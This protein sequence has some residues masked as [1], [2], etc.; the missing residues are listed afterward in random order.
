MP[1]LEH[2][3]SDDES[4]EDTEKE[5]DEHDELDNDDHSDDSSN[6]SSDCEVSADIAICLSDSEEILGLMSWISFIH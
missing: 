3:P 4:S 1:L 6:G 2:P 5:D